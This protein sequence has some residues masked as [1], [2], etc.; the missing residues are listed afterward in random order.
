MHAHHQCIKGEIT[1]LI[2]LCNK[3]CEYIA[4]GKLSEVWISI[5]NII[6]GFNY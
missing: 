6:I 5:I 1:K 3:L 4:A 2:T